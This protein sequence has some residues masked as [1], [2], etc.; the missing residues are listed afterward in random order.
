MAGRGTQTGAGSRPCRLRKR[1]LRY[2]EGEGGDVASPAEPPKKATAARARGGRR[3]HASL[4]QSP[5]P[6][7][8]AAAS[9]AVQRPAPMPPSQLLSKYLRARPTRTQAE[10]AGV[11]LATYPPSARGLALEGATQCFLEQHHRVR[12]RAGA[13]GTTTAGRK[14]G[15]N[16]APCDF[17]I[18]RKRVE[19]KSAQL[20]WNPSQHYWV[21]KWHNVKPDEHDDLYLALYT[22]SGVYLY[23][24]D[25]D[26]GMCT[27]GKRQASLGGG[28]QVYG[29]RN[30]TSIA[31]ATAVV[32]QKLAGH[33]ESIAH[34]TYK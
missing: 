31:R 7:R 5:T 10:Y 3:A 4:R 32:C 28:V 9:T 23:K 12:A 17:K 33:I 20:T 16:M 26:Y 34:L 13:C 27:K 29:P 21:A 25:G 1:P 30:E 24:H 19:V 22:P 18:R 8:K 11:P 2:A 6:S 15:R 14:R